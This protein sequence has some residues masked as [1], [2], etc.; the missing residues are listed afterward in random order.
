MI[1]RHIE[2]KIASLTGKC[3]SKS[4]WI[5]PHTIQ[6][7]YH[8]NT[9]NRMVKMWSKGNSHALLVAIEI[10]EAIIINSIEVPQKTKRRDTL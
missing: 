9:I 3:K 6:N 4:E 10:G 7:A 8:Q 1:K 5:S 2:R